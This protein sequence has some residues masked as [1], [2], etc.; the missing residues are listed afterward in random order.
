MHLF[1]LHPQR[2]V[3]HGQDAAGVVLHLLV[4]LVLPRFAAQHRLHL[5]RA[6]A[7]VQQLEREVLHLMVQLLVHLLHSCHDENV[8]IVVFSSVQ[9][10]SS[11]V[12]CSVQFQFS[13]VF[14]SVPVQC[15]VRF[16]SSSVSCS[17][18]FQFSLVF[19][20]DLVQCRV[21]FSSSSVSCSVQL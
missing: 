9:L 13:L 16:G 3:D 2:C 20:S 14:G 17:V 7:L 5:V 4:L 12:S 19:G 21:Q 15:R 8:M 1:L 6:L 18:Q 10:S 11:S